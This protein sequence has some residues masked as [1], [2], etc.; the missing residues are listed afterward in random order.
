MPKS[1]EGP[2]QS[3]R[4]LVLLARIDP[5]DAY[6]IRRALHEDGAG[7]Y[8]VREVAEL[9]DLRSHIQCLSADVLVLDYPTHRADGIAALKE[10]RAAFPELPIVAMTRFG[11]D[12]AA[13]L[14]LD[15]GAQDHCVKGRVDAKPILRSIQYVIE[16]RRVEALT[17]RMR[18]SD[19]LASVGQLA[20]GVAHEINNPIAF[21]LANL[22]MMKERL[23]KLESVFGSINTI[24]GSWFCPEDRE[25][26][27]TLIADHGVADLLGEISEMLDD[28]LVGME[29]IRGITRS[30]QG[31]SRIDQE[32]ADWI[33]FNDVVR[34]ACNMAFNEIRHRAVLVKDLGDVPRIVADRDKLARAV[35]NV[36]LNAAHSIEP[37]AAESNRITVR[38]RHENGMIELTVE[39]T[40]CGISGADQDRVFEPFF[41]TK[42]RE[43]GTGL[44]LSQCAEAMR[45]HRGKIRLQSEAGEGT[46]FF[47]TLPEDTGLEPEPAVEAERPIAES[48]ARAR[49]LLIDDD[50]MVRRSYRRV[51]APHHDVVE[52]TGGKH[53]LGILMRDREFDV[54]LCDLIMPDC[55]GTM[56][57]ETL[58]KMAPHLRARM[59]FMSG[60]AFTASAK[61]FVAR[62]HVAVLEKPLSC[63]DLL[64]AVA[65]A[66]VSQG[67]ESGIRE[68]AGATAQP[69]ALRA[70]RST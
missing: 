45:A 27:N 20:A 66:T 61:S 50:V 7:A 56:L 41:T 23:G 52:A 68:L 60:G 64:G 8:R 10:V 48:S 33:K 1:D 65:Q 62:T 46:C 63:E 47:L 15:E 2:E 25:V 19:H 16:R 70:A 24:G 32:K 14:A 35:L 18:R 6:L 26:I 4:T 43:V 37:G 29:R 39:D 22:N 17:R 42:S 44:G 21:L 69:P 9:Y 57:Y 30:L 11:D 13:A 31:F 5:G 40:G 38:T 53:A 49:I 28:N 3:Q 36:L 59:V 67:P 51:L 12:A 54:L 34:S 58:G 55:D